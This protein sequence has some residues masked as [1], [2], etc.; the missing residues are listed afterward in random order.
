MVLRLNKNYYFTLRLGG[1]IGTNTKDEL[2]SLWGLL[3]FAILIKI[4]YICIS[5]GSKVIIEWINGNFNL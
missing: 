5:G 2:L 3:K 1:G 4:S